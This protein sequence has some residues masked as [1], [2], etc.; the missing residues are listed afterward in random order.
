MPNAPVDRLVTFVTRHARA[1]AAAWLSAQVA[2]AGTSWSHADFVAA[3]SAAGRRLGTAPIA[4]PQVEAR[5]SDGDLVNSLAAGRGLD[6]VGRMA[7]LV[8]LRE[9][10]PGA[11]GGDLEALV[12][13]LFYRGDAREKQAV[14]RALP[15]LSA[16]ARFLEVAVEACRSSVQTVFE[17]I[18]CENPYPREHFSEIAFNQLVIKALFTETAAARIVGLEDRVGSELVRMAEGYGSERRAAGRAVP[19]DIARISGLQRRDR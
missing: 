14:L 15:L 13:E 17:A 16:P 9:S 7:L 1:E 4:P 2:A 18:A 19:E 3:F 5:T 10:G 6:E 12:K 8:A 11:T